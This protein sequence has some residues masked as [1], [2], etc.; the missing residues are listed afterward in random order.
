VTTRIHVL[1][2]IHLEFAPFTPPDVGADVVVLAGD[3]GTKFHG[4]EW[5]NDTFRCPVVYLLGNH[6]YYGG[7]LARVIA[8][9]RANAAPHVH[10]LDGE[11]VSLAGVHFLGATLW[12][13][14]DLFGAELRT[15]AM[16]A[17]ESVMTDFKRIRVENHGHFVRLRAAYTRRVFVERREWLAA[18]LAHGQ[19]GRTVVVTHH[20]PHRG[21]LAE[22]FAQDLVS[23][24][25]VSDL[26][27]LLGK[28]ALWIHGHTHTSFD[29]RVE[30]TRVLC[31]PRGYAPADVNPGF[32]PD[33]V[34]EV[35][36]GK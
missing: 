28:S 1:S 25:Y 24:A 18:E 11:S 4:V 6:E 35:D 7:D 3:I 34:V 31:N 32:R 8:K 27:A 17:A 20:A 22:E 5:A 30:G 36:A 21:S 12:T 19:P 14:F 9:C 10:V 13:D 26:T 29:Y 2:D 16:Y 15:Q 33:L 23:A